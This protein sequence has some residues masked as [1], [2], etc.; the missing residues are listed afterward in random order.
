V[1][2]I[3]L[4]WIGEREASAPM[5]QHVRLHVARA[6]GRQ[7]QL[8]G[9][10]GRPADAWDA[11][12][13]QHSSTRILK[14]LTEAGP[15]DGKVLGITD[16]DLFIPILTFVFGEAQLGGAAAVVSTARLVDPAARVDPR[17]M[18]ERLAKE[19]VHELGHAFGLVHCGTPGCAMSR[20][21]SLRD[22]DLKNGDLCQRC[23]AQLSGP[24]ERGDA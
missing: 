2:G 18:H 1:E 23:R 24:S 20:S 5:I 15:K 13:R 4:W 19:A 6:F 14:W 3:H 8:C 21:A 9:S 22:V 11:R 10:K 17:V 12:R 7:V 16:V